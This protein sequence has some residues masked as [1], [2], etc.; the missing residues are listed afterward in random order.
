MNGWS[1]S[2]DYLKLFFKESEDFSWY[3]PSNASSVNAWDGDQLF[4]R[5]ILTSHL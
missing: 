2:L 1:L 4:V 3:D 5:R